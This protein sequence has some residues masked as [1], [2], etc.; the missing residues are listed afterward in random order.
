MQNRNYKVD[1]L[2]FKTIE[3]KEVSYVLGF[4]W[5]DGYLNGIHI[6]TEIVSDDFVEIEPIFDNIGKWS[7]THR[8]RKG[9][10]PQSSICTGQNPLAQ[11]LTSYG[12]RNK[13]SK[14]PSVLLNKIPEELKKY[15]WRGY[16]DG[17]GCFYCNENKTI[18]QMVIS[19]CYEQDWSHAVNLFEKL[20]IKN[21]KI[22][23]TK[24]KNGHKNS[25]IRVCNIDGISKFGNYI[26][27]KNYDHIGLS[28]KRN[29][30]L[31]T[32]IRKVKI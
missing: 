24:Q 26:Y 15:W 1:P 29:K 14:T 18:R 30:F 8:K 19:S 25:R 10:R 27:G 13:S 16:F 21:Y 20:K 4:L 23:K 22:K 5:A 28:R 12:F 6:K 3:T 7:K 31:E 9:M 32:I 17:D 11:I 2:K